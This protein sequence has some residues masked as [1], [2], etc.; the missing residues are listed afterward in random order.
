MGVFRISQGGGAALIFWGL[1]VYMLRSG[2]SR[3]VARGARCAVARGMPTK[4]IF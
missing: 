4:E 2:M 3:A 1:W